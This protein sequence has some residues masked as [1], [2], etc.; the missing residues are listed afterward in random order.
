M[1]EVGDLF[2][3]DEILGGL[4]ARRAR[5][6]VFL[7]ERQTVRHTATRE[8]GPMALAGEGAAHGRELEWF[9]AFAAAGEDEL[10]RPSIREIEAAAG[11]WASLV[12]EAPAVRAAAARVLGKRHELDRERSRHSGRA[13]PRCPGRRGGLPPPG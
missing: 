12:P 4:P 8:V 3:R 13:W 6:L 11:S 2:S 1:S 5:S 9:E 7:I 10:H